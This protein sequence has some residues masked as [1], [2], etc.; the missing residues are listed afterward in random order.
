MSKKDTQGIVSTNS[1]NY[2]STEG[3]IYSF[4]KVLNVNFFHLFVKKK[5]NVQ[6]CV[7]NYS[8]NSQHSYASE[9]SLTR[10]AVSLNVS[11]VAL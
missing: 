7:S 9:S 3:E 2:R 8:L 5:K 4:N 10:F 6:K 11:S 1:P